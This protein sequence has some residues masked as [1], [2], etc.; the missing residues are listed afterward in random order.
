M[1]IRALT[2][3][4]AV[5]QGI[6][7]VEQRSIPLISNNAS[8]AAYVL[9]APNAT[10]WVNIADTNIEYIGNN[11]TDSLL[12]ELVPTKA[13]KTV[14]P[15][16]EMRLIPW[17]SYR[18]VQGQPPPAAGQYNVT[19]NPF[20]QLNI[21]DRVL[22]LTASDDSSYNM[23]GQSMSVD[24]V[25]GQA[26]AYGIF[27][28]AKSGKTNFFLSFLGAI[29]GAQW[30]IGE[31]EVP[32]A[33]PTMDNYS[34]FIHEMLTSTY[35]IVAMDSLAYI[36]LISPLHSGLTSGAASKDPIEIMGLLQQLFRDLG[37]IALFVVNPLVK[38]DKIEDYS[39]YFEGGATGTFYVQRMNPGRDIGGQ[40][41][42][43]WDVQISV[44]PTRSNSIYTV[45][46]PDTYLTPI[47]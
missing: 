45:T 27:G 12:G 30:R 24:L 43:T 26:G 40:S 4:R 17:V 33:S 28:G 13:P 39:E 41:T 21:A 34:L 38:K 8:T 14:R 25:I 47:V 3:H 6:Y 42:V 7:Q 20:T 32:C 37:K 5:T 11:P 19:G 36:A 29:G 23:G 46:L 18:N 22:D 9:D 2:Q 15:H 10:P 16:I 44:P 35:P 1:N 31:R